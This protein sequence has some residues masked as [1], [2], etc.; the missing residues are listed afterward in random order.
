M[1][2]EN[3]S[4]FVLFLIFNIEFLV[5]RFSISVYF[6]QFILIVAASSIGEELF[7]R[8]AVQVWFH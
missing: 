3:Y 1:A 5:L 4:F 7:Y 6:L 2:G 8:V